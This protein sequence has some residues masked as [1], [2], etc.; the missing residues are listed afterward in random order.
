MPRACTKKLPTKPI[1]EGRRCRSNTAPLSLCSM[2]NEKALEIQAA[3]GQAAKDMVKA[4]IAAGKPNKGLSKARHA[5]IVADVSEEM[6]SSFAGSTGEADASK[7]L[8]LI[9][10]A[11][12]SGSLLNASQ[13]RQELEKAGILVKEQAL[14]SE[15][16]VE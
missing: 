3:A 14:S 12:Y 4:Q 15:Y 8:R 13:L 7:E 9:L 10:R 16:G 1:A 5:A 11:A 2:T 6:A